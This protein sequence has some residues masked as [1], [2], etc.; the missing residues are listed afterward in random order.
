[1]HMMFCSFLKEFSCWLA[2]SISM[3]VLLAM[4]SLTVQDVVVIS[5]IKGASQQIMSVPM[6]TVSCREVC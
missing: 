4:V 6:E 5:Q 3:I 1:M 2:F